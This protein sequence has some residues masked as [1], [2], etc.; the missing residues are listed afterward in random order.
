MTVCCLCCLVHR[1]KFGCRDYHWVICVE[2]IGKGGEGMLYLQ[3]VFNSHNGNARRLFAMVSHSY[4]L[5]SN[6]EGSLVVHPELQ[7]FL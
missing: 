7:E 4:D 3:Y 6:T 1:D 5:R 2:G